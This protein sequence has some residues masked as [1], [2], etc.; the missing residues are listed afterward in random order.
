MNSV[1]DNSELSN[2]PQNQLLHI[3]PSININNTDNENTYDS[4]MND[5]FESIY[6]R[7]INRHNLESKELLKRKMGGETIRLLDFILSKVHW[8]LTL[9]HI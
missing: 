7:K 9:R 3:N 5:V 6:R 2:P 8:C 4:V 1:S